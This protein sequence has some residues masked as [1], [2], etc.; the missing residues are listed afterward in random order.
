KRFSLGNPGSHPDSDI[1]RDSINIVINSHYMLTRLRIITD[2]FI[3][4]FI[5]DRD[6]YVP[7]RPLPFG[8]NNNESVLIPLKFLDHHEQGILGRVINPIAA[9]TLGIIVTKI[10]H[11]SPLSP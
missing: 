8:L 4:A 9:L 2:D 5:R 7:I 10:P 6:R 11:I 3:S 1:S